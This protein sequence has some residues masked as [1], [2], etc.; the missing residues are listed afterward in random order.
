MMPPMNNPMM[1]M[2]QMARNGGNPMQMLQQM[3]GQNPQAAQAMRLIQGKN[4]Q[5]LRQT[6]ENMAKQ[7]GTSVEEI[8]R[9]LGIPMK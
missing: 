6:A 7:R 5:Q 3:A 4:P 8:A 1:A 2:L 9:Q